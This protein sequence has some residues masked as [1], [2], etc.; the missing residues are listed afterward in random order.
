MSQRAFVKPQSELKSELKFEKEKEMEN[1]N[2]RGMRE[3]AI[4]FQEDDRAAG[5]MTQH[6]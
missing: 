6:T 1:L 4:M 2:H 5:S 3:N